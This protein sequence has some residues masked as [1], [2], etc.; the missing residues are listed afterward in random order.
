M[1][2]SR[3]QKEGPPVFSHEFVIQNHADIISC[4]CMVV[5]MG[6]IPQVYI[7][8]VHRI[9]VRMPYIHRIRTYTVCTPYV[10]VNIVF[11]KLARTVG[12]VLGGR[13]WRWLDHESVLKLKV[14]W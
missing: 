9:Y 13:S 3:N 8:Y 5:F 1:L 6:L 4:L 14:L 12:V 7:P 2:R 10:Y 11:K